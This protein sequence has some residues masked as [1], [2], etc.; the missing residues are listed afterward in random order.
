VQGAHDPVEHDPSN[1]LT[2]LLEQPN[3]ARG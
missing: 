3:Q 2:A 1:H